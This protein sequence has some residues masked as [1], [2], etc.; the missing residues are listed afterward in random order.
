[1]EV[2]TGAALPADYVLDLLPGNAECSLTIK[3]RQVDLSGLKSFLDY[4]GLTQRWERNQLL[5][6]AQ[7]SLHTGVRMSTVAWFIFRAPFQETFQDEIRFSR[8]HKRLIHRLSQLV[9]THL[10]KVLQATLPTPQSGDVL[11]PAKRD[12]RRA[13]GEPKVQNMLA[14]DRFM[15]RGGGFVSSTADSSLESLDLGGILPPNYNRTTAD[16]VYRHIRKTGEML[17]QEMAQQS[18]KSLAFLCDA[19]PKGCVDVW[20]PVVAA[21][22]FASVATLQ[23]LSALLPSTADA[24]EKMKAAQQVADSTTKLLV[25]SRDKKEHRPKMPRIISGLHQDKLT[26]R[27]HIRAVGNVLNHLGVAL[28]DIFPK[29]PL[30]PLAPTSEILATYEM[31]G[32]TMPFVASLQDATSRWDVPDTES[33][34][35]RLIVCPDEGSP[36]F[37]SYVFLA[38]RNAAINLCRDELHKLSQHCQRVLASS[39]MMKRMSTLTSWLFRCRKSPWKTHGLGCNL[40]AAGKRYLD[41]VTGKHLAA[42]DDVLQQ[43]FGH[44]TLIENNIA[45]ECDE[46]VNFDRTGHNPFAVLDKA[47]QETPEKSWDKALCDEQVHTLWK[48]GREL[49][50]PFRD[51]CI[52]LKSKKLMALHDHVL[53]MNSDFLERSLSNLAAEV[54]CSSRLHQPPDIIGIA[55]EVLS[56]GF[57]RSFLDE[58]VLKEQVLGF[59]SCCHELLEYAL[60]LRSF[61]CRAAAFCSTQATAESRSDLLKAAENE[62]KLIREIEATASGASVLK[63]HALHTTFQVYREIMATMQMHNFKD[64]QAIADMVQA[65]FPRWGQSANLE[66]IFRE[67][68]QATKRVGHVENSMPNLTCVA[69]RAMSRRVCCGDECPATPTLS[70]KDWEGQVVR[71]LKDKM[72]HPTSAPPCKNV[73]IDDILKTGTSPIDSMSSMWAV[74]LKEI[75]WSFKGPLPAETVDERR[76]PASTHK[77]TET[78]DEHLEVEIFCYTLHVCPTSMESKCGGILFRRGPKPYSL[79]VHLFVSEN[80]MSITSAALSDILTAY[81]IRMPKNSSKHAKITKLMTLDEVKQAIGDAGVARMEAKLLEIDK[82]RHSKKKATAAEKANDEDPAVAACCQLLEELGDE[83]EAEA[84]EKKEEKKEEA[85]E[86]RQC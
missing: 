77:A 12:G 54:L 8:L 46:Q 40:C 56:I 23:K 82:N 57:R 78:R 79:L 30:K 84:E 26:A 43:L 69:V 41:V 21:N 74:R 60:Y 14:I 80:I 10:S 6:P 16:F 64:C 42:P 11:H 52:D 73:R 31:D 38:T 29:S 32:K 48:F 4:T 20:L 50:K 44:H 70:E 27:E 72:W 45:P 63:Q 7:R 65:W 53:K 81:S 33:A 62:Y 15:T 83:S 36:M 71:N 47:S 18:L 75:V 35:V 39:P 17:S 24:S 22:Q 5:T 49:M 3:D 28:D 37:S 58:E 25:A 76:M 51:M 61:P 85:S 66:Q 67:M 34:H 68:E 2:I 9:E 13:R 19:S 55:D 86:A 1:M 59:L